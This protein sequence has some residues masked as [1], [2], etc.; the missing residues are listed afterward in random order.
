MDYNLNDNWLLNMSVWWMDI[1]TDIKFKAAGEDQSIHTR[2]DP[3]V[4]MFAAG[5]RF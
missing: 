4:F 5:Y 2:I 3:W 1:D